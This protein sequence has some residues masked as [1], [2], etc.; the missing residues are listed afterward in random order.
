MLFPKS[1]AIS[2]CEQ[3]KIFMCNKCLNYHKELFKNH[4]QYNIDLKKYGERYVMQNSYTLYGV[5]ENIVVCIDESA[6]NVSK[7]KERI[8]EKKCYNIYCG[9]DWRDHI[10]KYDPV[11]QTCPENC[12][13]Y[14]Y[15]TDDNYCYDECPEGANCYPSGA[16]PN[17]ITVKIKGTGNQYILN[18]DFSPCPHYLYFNGKRIT[19]DKTDCST[20]FIPPDISINTVKLEWRIKLTNLKT[21]P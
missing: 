5:R 10:R 6:N 8:L 20:L 16:L 17:S 15:E 21:N 9:D 3:C 18:P 13:G 7:L 12:L 2:F 4:Q 19:V 14:N 1:N 11:N